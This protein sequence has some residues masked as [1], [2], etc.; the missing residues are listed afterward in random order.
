[1]KNII[2][3]ALA[4]SA[5]LTASTANAQIIN[6]VSLT[7]TAGGKG[8]SAWTSLDLTYSNFSVSIT[9]QGT[10]DD[11][12]QQFAYLDWGNAGLGVCND[13]G[14]L[15][16][17]SVDTAYSGN[18]Q[19][20]CNP[21]SDDNVTVQESLTFVFDTD[22]VI[23][24]IWFNNSHDD[25]FGAGDL[26]DINGDL[27]SPTVDSYVN[28][29]ESFGYYIVD[30]GEDFVVSFV[31]EQFYISGL[32]VRAIPEPFAIAL[33]GMGLIGLSLRSRRN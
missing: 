23:D 13:A 8:E 15:N 20:L 16:G 27:V 28:D 19:N 11:D 29:P 1:M 31:N 25:G 32:S 5:L 18:G 26:I 3:L 6:F 21:A 12:N 22:V 14:G 17:K 4:I 10:G 7:Q 2:K 30:A 33:M 24:A 9:G